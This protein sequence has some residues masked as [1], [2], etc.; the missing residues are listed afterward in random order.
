MNLCHPRKE[1]EI[2]MCIISSTSLCSMSPFHRVLT[3]ILACLEVEWADLGIQ[4]DWTPVQIQ[5]Y[6][7]SHIEVSNSLLREC[8][9]FIVK[10]LAQQAQHPYH[11]FSLELVSQ[12]RQLFCSSSRRGWTHAKLLAACSAITLSK[13]LSGSKM[14]QMKHPATCTRCS[15]QFVSTISLKLH[16]PSCVHSHPSKRLRMDTELK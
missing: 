2:E 15:R 14:P 6:L 13:H 5:L 8:P 10:T 11:G 1:Q 3:M 9:S 12:I 16:E 4:K 7:E